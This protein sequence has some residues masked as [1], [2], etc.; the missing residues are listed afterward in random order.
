[1]R[2]LAQVL[3]HAVCTK[4]PP[5][6]ESSD[7]F[8]EHSSWRMESAEEFLRRMGDL[9]VAGRTV[10]DVGCGGGELAVLMARR[11]AAGVLGVDIDAASIRLADEQAR[12]EA[13]DVD[14]RV[15]FAAIERLSDIGDERFDVIVS[16]DSF[17]H[18]DDPEGF[19]RDAGHHLK[20]DGLL[21]IG[22]GPLWKSPYG[23]HLNH[24]TPLPYAHLLFP[25]RVIMLE[26]R[27]YAPGKWDGAMSWGEVTGGLNR[28]TFERFTEIMKRSGYVPEHFDT[29]VKA[30]RIGKALRLLRRVPGLREYVTINVYSA[31]RRPIDAPSA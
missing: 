8:H 13:P 6:A 23:G 10:L 28:M 3:F 1:M 5:R 11:G 30:G 24:M 15:R 2:S 14:G 19:V 20:P 17:E 18:F 7:L 9:Q 4:A 31:W 12:R 26:R 29:N 16:K 25:E 21:V 27:R 22:F